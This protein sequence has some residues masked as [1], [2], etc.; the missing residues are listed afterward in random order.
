[1]T[2]QL[3]QLDVPPG[4]RILFHD[5]SWSEF[6][7]ILAELGEYRASRLTYDNGVLE[8]VTPLSEHE[9]DKEILGDLLKALLEELNLEF[10]TLGSTTFKNQAMAKGIEPDQCFYIENEAKIRGKK[11][12]DLTIDPPPDIAIEI[13]VTSRTHPSTYEALGVPQL[14]RKN[15]DCL[16]INILQNGKYIEVTRSPTFPNLS[17]TEILLEYLEQSKIIGR[18]QVIKAFRQWVR[19]RI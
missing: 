1:M 17:I 11:R 2:L 13:D 8:I 19:E 14:W 9:D 5:V 7:N 3:R 15:G 6:E 10:R 12:L 4:Q 18:N 16:Q